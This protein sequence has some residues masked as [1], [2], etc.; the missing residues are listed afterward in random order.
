MTLTTALDVEE[1]RKDFPVLDRLVH[2]DKPLVYLDNAATTQ[3]P[4]GPVFDSS[5]RTIRR[6]PV[7]NRGSTSE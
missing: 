3:I 4:H 2:D 1:V 5:G 6:Q 7:M